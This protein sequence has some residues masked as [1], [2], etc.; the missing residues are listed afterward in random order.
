[1]TQQQN[2]AGTVRDARTVLRSLLGSVGPFLISLSILAFIVAAPV[3]AAPHDK[4][5]KVAPDLKEETR[6]GSP[7]RSVRLVVTLDGR[8]GT[9]IADK[10]E[11]LGGKVKGHFRNVQA[12]AIDLPLEAVDELA[13]TDG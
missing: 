3:T 12:M 4:K 1:M 2:E 7:S 9:E 13:E 11:A 6:K 8:D 10:V 5:S